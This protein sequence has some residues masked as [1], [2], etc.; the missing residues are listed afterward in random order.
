MLAEPIPSYDRL[1]SLLAVP[2]LREVMEKL[3]DGPVTQRDL[4]SRLGY[5]SSAL[6]RGMRQL[7]DAGI[8]SRDRSH[9]PYEL[10]YPYETRALLAAAAEMSSRVLRARADVDAAHAVELAG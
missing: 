4:R 2:L 8:V 5:S 1:L 6:S 3:L 10:T 9:A 7:E